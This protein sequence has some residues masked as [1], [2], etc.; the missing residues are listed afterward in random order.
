MIKHTVT[1]K[2]KYA[3][4]SEE[5]TIFLKAAAELRAIPRVKNFQ[6]LRQISPKSNFDYGLSMDFDSM[7]DYNVYCDHP[8]HTAFV[9]TYWAG[10][11]E[12]FLELDYELF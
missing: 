3:K 11:V 7:E 10:Y 12:D 9:G 1:F 4:G 5:E 6:C 8:E 2:L